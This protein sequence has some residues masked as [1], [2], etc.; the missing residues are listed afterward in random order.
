MYSNLFTALPRPMKL[1]HSANCTRTQ[2]NRGLLTIHNEGGGYYRMIVPASMCMP[3]WF[4]F[5]RQILMHQAHHLE[6]HWIA[7]GQDRSKSLVSW[8]LIIYSAGKKAPCQQFMN[9]WEFRPAGQEWQA[10]S[11]NDQFLTCFIQTAAQTDNLDYSG[12]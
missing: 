10:A 12:G 3:R 1:T 5:L 7:E 8:D 11:S 6:N 9:N 4:S 2:S